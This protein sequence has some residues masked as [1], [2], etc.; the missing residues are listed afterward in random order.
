MRC[1][2]WKLRPD[3]RWKEYWTSVSVLKF[4]HTRYLPPYLT[5]RDSSVRAFGVFSH[6]TKLSRNGSETGDVVL[7]D[8]IQDRFFHK[9]NVETGMVVPDN[10]WT[11]KNNLFTL[12]KYLKKKYEIWQKMGIEKRSISSW[13]AGRSFVSP[14]PASSNTGG[15]AWVPEDDLNESNIEIWQDND[16]FHSFII[17]S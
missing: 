13:N 7:D 2:T 16:L 1:L 3:L 4:S 10:V 12:T 8:V 9:H 17:S 5:L 11:K 6:P 15:N 14:S